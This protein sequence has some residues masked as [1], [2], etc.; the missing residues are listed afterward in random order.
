M[1]S[2]YVY[3]GAGLTG[4]TNLTNSL[5]MGAVRVANGAKLPSSGLTVATPF[6]IYVW[7]NYNVT[8]ASGTRTGVNNQTANYTYPAALMGDA[9]TILSA[10]WSDAPHAKGSPTT[11]TA[12]T[13]NA[14]CLEGIVQ[15]VGSSYSGGV[16]NFLRLLENWGGI[17]LTY[18][19]SIVVMFPSQV[20][21]G[22]WNG[23][24]YS[25]PTR[26]WAFDTNLKNQSGL[27]P[28]TPQTKAVIR[29]AWYGQ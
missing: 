25:V 9:M 27:P 8:G 2:I 16:E 22:S 23:S 17:K 4:T 19:G 15:S 11:P 24:Y 12:T 21:V 5:F 10:N 7:G 28:L 13:V 18:N 6:P 29:S 14:A 26:A 3:N 1:N 20:A